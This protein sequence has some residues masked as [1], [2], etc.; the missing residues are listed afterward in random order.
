MRT[1]TTNRQ[2]A[3]I[4]CTASAPTAGMTAEKPATT[5]KEARTGTTSCSACRRL[6]SKHTN[7][8][9][10]PKRK[11]GNCPTNDPA[12]S[13]PRSRVGLV[14]AVGRNSS[15]PGKPRNMA[16]IHLDFLP[17]HVSKGDILTLLDGACGL[18]QR[19][20][21]RIELR[22]N[23][24]VIEVPD[25]WEARLIKGPGRPAVRRPPASGLGPPAP[26]AASRGGED[27]FQRLGRLAGYGKPGRGPAGGRAGPA[28][29]ARRRPSGRAIASWTWSWPTNRPAWA[30]VTWLNWPADAAPLPWTR[31]DVGSPV[32]LSPAHGRA[33]SSPYRGVVC[34]RQRAGRSAWPWTAARRP[35]RA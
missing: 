31:L 10:S 26:P 3:A 29:L 23:Q 6:L 16:L 12:I 13:V 7:P 5:A 32:V 27:H 4:C 20:V 17:R 8:H 19:R 9:T 15:L 25:G 24:A 2:A 14:C 21:G 22:G 28:A 1:C 30:A 35:G 33:P 18:G 11:R 34:E